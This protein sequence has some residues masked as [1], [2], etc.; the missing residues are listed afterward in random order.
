[1]PILPQMIEHLLKII[2]VPGFGKP[3]CLNSLEENPLCV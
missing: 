1:M 2:N 3:G